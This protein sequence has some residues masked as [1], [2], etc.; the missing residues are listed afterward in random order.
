MTGEPRVLLLSHSGE[1]MCTDAVA[2]ALARRGARAVRLDTDDFP[3]ALALRGELGFPGAR[4]LVLDDRPLVAHAVWLWRLWPARLDERL[5]DEHRDAA[6]RESFAALRGL[7]DLMPRVPWID[8]LDVGRAA[9]DKARQLRLACDL[10]LAIPPTLITADPAAAREF[11]VAQAGQVVAKL[12]TPLRQS[13]AGGGLPTRLLRR[14]DLDALAGLRHCPMIFQRY[15]PKA[16]E[17]RIAWVDGRALVGALDGAAC[18]VDWRYECSASWQPH[19]LPEPVHRRLAALMTRLGL[20]QG[21][22]DMIVTPSGEY[23]FLE[24]NPTGEWMML[25]KELGLPI[26]DALAAALLRLAN[27]SQ[28]EASER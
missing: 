24:V 2:G 18:G 20:R 6:R 19:D 25:E 8:A 10:G 1:P 22:I 12:Q 15:V 16:M 17:L 9:D 3:A 7:L 21:A 5:T 23:V 27:E 13:M 28:R 26:S 11:F 14:D 4:G